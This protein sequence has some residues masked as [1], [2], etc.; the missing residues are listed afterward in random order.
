M[1]PANGHAAGAP[2]KSH[3][4]G[5]DEALADALDKASALGPPDTYEVDVV[6]SATV[7]VTNPGTIQGYSV[8]LNPHH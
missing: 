2:G 1:P 4:Q 3:H 8:T 7:K 6:F 5:W